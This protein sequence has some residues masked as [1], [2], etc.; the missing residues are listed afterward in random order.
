VL[1]TEDGFD[2]MTK[3]GSGGDWAARDCWPGSRLQPNVAP[4]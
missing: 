2:V 4:S 1:C 3:G